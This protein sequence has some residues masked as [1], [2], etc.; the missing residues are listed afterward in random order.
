[1]VQKREFCPIGLATFQAHDLKAA[2]SK[3]LAMR[4][5]HHRIVP[6]DGNALLLFAEGPRAVV[7]RHCVSEHKRAKVQLKSGVWACAYVKV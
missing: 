5:R 3:K 2:G 1:M 6:L 7:E 4:H